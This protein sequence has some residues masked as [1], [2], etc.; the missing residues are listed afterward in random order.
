M[1]K[2][3]NERSVTMDTNTTKI[4]PSLALYHANA[5]CTGCAVKFELQPAQDFAEGFI[6]ARFAN[7]KTVGNR[8]AKT[9]TYPTFDWDGEIAVK[10]TLLDIC[11]M[12]QVFRGEC[13]SID[14][15]KGLYHR[16]TEGATRV[17]LRHIIEPV[18][19]YSFEVFHVGVDGRDADAHIMLT[20]A[21]AL[22]LC[23]AME[24]SIGIITFGVQ[25][26]SRI[27]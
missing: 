6:F 22:G 13:E 8:F 7:Q 4:R 19:A 16:S 17:V 10:L 9:P 18:N 26:A 20:T 14:D 2:D 5:C 23:L 12:I 27:Q 3:I 1:S 24:N 21:E 11:K 15:G 25:S